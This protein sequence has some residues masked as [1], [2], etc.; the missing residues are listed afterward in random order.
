MNFVT[1]CH[2]CHF[3]HQG[4]LLQA[5]DFDESDWNTKAQLTA[6]IKNNQN[7][8]SHTRNPHSSE[9]KLS[10]FIVMTYPPYRCMETTEFYNEI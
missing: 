2:F 10:G 1:I 9:K 4:I 5:L 8:Y 6:K 7:L 3:R